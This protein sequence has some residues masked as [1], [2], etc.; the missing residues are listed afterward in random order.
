MKDNQRLT[1]LHLDYVYICSCL[2]VR[3]ELAVATADGALTRLRWS[4]IKN[5]K[6]SFCLQDLPIATDFLQ[7]RG[8][9]SPQS[10]I[11]ILLFW[12]LFLKIFRLL[13]VSRVL[14]KVHVTLNS[15]SQVCPSFKGRFRKKDS[16]T[17][18]C[19]A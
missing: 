3:E 16:L 10:M 9:S 7:S 17:I 13:L 6:S 14:Q 2:C 18:N 19:T 4:G 8:I 11:V 15:A 5:E 12:N 1:A